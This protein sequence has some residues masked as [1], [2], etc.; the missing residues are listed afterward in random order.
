MPI[1][2]TEIK[3]ALDDFEKDDFMG[4]K[5]RLKKEIGS[6]VKNYY[7]DKLELQKDLEPTADAG[8]GE[9]ETGTGETGTGE[10]ETST[11]ETDTGE[12]GTGEGETGSEE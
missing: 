7:K 1:D 11:G 4:A 12:T 2:N 5:D 3:K 10:G 8:T 9:G 6:A